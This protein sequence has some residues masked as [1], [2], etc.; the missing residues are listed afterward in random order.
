M[1]SQSRGREIVDKYKFRLQKRLYYISAEE[2]K[3]K[4]KPTPVNG[5]RAQFIERY[6]EVGYE[7]AKT[8][9]NNGYEKEVFNDDIL[10]V[11]IGEN[12]L[13][14]NTKDK[15][16]NSYRQE[17]NREFAYKVASEINKMIG[18]EVYTKSVVDSIIDTEIKKQR[19]NQPDKDD[20]DA[21]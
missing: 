21:R 10:L 1:K 7:Q 6:K 11:W 16:F 4:T 20:D 2:R 3:K 5:K 18:A 13:G 8:E 19:T 9:I 17:N 12:I 15:I 14:L